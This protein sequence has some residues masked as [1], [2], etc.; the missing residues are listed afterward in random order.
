M[1]LGLA[2]L[3][4]GLIM[5][6]TVI[7]PQGVMLALPYVCVGIGCGIFGQGM[8]SIIGHKA[9]KT[10]PDMEKQMEIELNDERNITIRTRAKAKAYDMMIFVFGALMIAF[11][12]MGVDLINIILLVIA[13]LFVVVYGVYCRCKYDKEM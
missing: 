13:Y 4:A 8:G 3:I 6:K 1:L 12:L 7:N 10:H 2:L 5:L 9:I 11:A